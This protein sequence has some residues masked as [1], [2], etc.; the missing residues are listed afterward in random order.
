M[1]SSYAPQPSH[2]GSR[3][4][5]LFNATLVELQNWLYDLPDSLRLEAG[6]RA[7]AFPQAYTL[8]MA[9][10]TAVILLANGTL[11]SKSRGTTS[12]SDDI[13]LLDK[14]ASCVCYEAAT[15]MCDVARKYRT[16]FGDFR[17]SAVSATHCLLS[18]ALVLIQV[19]S[20]EVEVSRRKAAE[21]NVDLCL[22][23]L[24]EL[25]VLWGIAGKTHRSLVRLKERKLGL[26][27][28]S[29]L[30]ADHLINSTLLDLAGSTGYDMSNPVLLNDAHS[31]LDPDTSASSA[32]DGFDFTAQLADIDFLNP[33]IW[34]NF[35]Q[36]FTNDSN[37]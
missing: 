11:A 16:V 3:R 20:N 17:L 14:R 5:T 18:A 9:F 13:D 7:N 31:L 23:S 35:G 27:T 30:V 2:T 36:G 10:H 28:A 6:G 12:A 22:Q 29:T 37:I 24:E 1:Y 19:A 32:T 26:T 25:S 15:N 34:G 33:S 4:E 8:H 21:S